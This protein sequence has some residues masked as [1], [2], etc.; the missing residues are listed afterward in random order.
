MVD[1]NKELKTTEEATLGMSRAFISPFGLLTVLVIVICYYYIEHT[2]YRTHLG[3]K[4]SRFSSLPTSPFL[5]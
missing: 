2:L 4:P 5:L 1:V 3:A